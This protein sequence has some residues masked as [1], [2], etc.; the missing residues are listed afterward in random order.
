MSIQQGEV[1]RLLR[2]V[3]RDQNIYDQLSRLVYDDIRQLARARRGEMKSSPTLQT[4][5]VVNEALIKLF[6]GDPQ[7]SDRRHLMCLMS[8]VIR[9]IIIDHA[10]R[11]MRQKRGSDA[12]RADIDLEDMAQP[13]PDIAHLLD[14]DAAIDRLEEVDPELAELICAHYFG[15]HSAEELADLHGVSRRTVHHRL[16]RASTW[17]RFELN[18]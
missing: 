13:S 2:Q 6:K 9:Q 4:T 12:I 15:G 8:R 11:H 1:T 18:H 16:Q 7:I 17:L 5:A 14:L 10:R 3:E